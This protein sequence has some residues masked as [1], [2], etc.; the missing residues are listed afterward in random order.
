MP[1]ERVIRPAAT[2]TR[3]APAPGLPTASTLFLQ[4]HVAGE[5]PPVWWVGCH[6]GAGT[7]T[8]S[9]LVGMGVDMGGVWPEPRPEE[10][11]PAVVLVCRATAAGTW[12]ATGAVRQWQ[13]RPETL[14]VRLLGI[15]A[16]AASP[17][18]APRIA[19]E[20]LQLLAGWVPTVWRIGWVEALLAADDPR[21]I[22]TPPDVAA[23]RHVVAAGT[24][25]TR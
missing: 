5:W 8:M 19:V 13:A 24:G 10:P 3:P 17:R 25:T 7:T 6:G 14:R 1:V 23:L 9:Q 4:H 2:T 12:A 15:A 18:R 11:A 20:R 21:D 16:V 22:G